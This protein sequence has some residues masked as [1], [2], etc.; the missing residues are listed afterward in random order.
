M[1]INITYIN[2]TQRTSREGKPFT[3][4][5]LK[6]SQYGEKYLS[7]FGNKAN[8]NWAIGQEVEIAEVKEVQKD[9][10]TYLNFEMAKATPQ[11]SSEVLQGVKHL[12][13][14][15][16]TIKRDQQKIIDHL[17]GK[18]RLDL[19]SAGTKVPDFSEVNDISPED[20]P[21]N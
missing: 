14:M 12:V 5:S 16:E 2:R 19:T 6:C 3:S 15:V 18:N 9:G 8:E 21:F 20:I 10:K 7:G 11:A 17:S 4:I 1:K 13:L